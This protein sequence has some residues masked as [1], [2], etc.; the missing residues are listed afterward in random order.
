LAVRNPSGSRQSLV[1]FDRK[2]RSVEVFAAAVLVCILAYSL[3]VVAG[4]V[5][6]GWRPAACT[7]SQP[8]S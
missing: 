1:E 6:H 5:A 7:I 3:F 8:R 2:Q 4:N